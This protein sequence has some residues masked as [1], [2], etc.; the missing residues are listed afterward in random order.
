MLIDVEYSFIL[1]DDLRFWG[2]TAWFCL[3]IVDDS[4]IY[5]ADLI[6]RNFWASS[7]LTGFWVIWK[8]CP[9]LVGLDWREYR[10]VGGSFDSF[11]A[12]TVFQF[13][14]ALATW[15]S[16]DSFVEQCPPIHTHNFFIPLKVFQLVFSSS[17][18]HQSCHSAHLQSF[19]F[20]WKLFSDAFVFVWPR[21]QTT[22][23]QVRDAG[24]DMQHLFTRLFQA[25]Y[26][27]VDM[28]ATDAK[29]QTSWSTL[30]GKCIKVMVILLVYP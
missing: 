26:C 18:L 28:E 24:F 13:S 22:H 27:K 29:I 21:S 3:M 12:F 4:V 11:W 14:L 20:H 30:N 8:S 17:W 23:S 2:G 19:N 10:R 5:N 6:E 25:E 15:C 1:E 9:G 7:L 16:E